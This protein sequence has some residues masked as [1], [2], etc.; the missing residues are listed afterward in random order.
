[1]FPT[2]FFPCLFFLTFLF[3]SVVFSS[4]LSL[5]FRFSLFL[6]FSFLSFSSLFFSFVFFQIFPFLCF[7]FLFC[8]FLKLNSRPPVTSTFRKPD[9]R[10]EPLERGYRIC[11][12]KWHSQ[13]FIMTTSGDYKSSFLLTGLCNRDLPI[14]RC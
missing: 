14:A 2:L 9:S 11:Q 10:H 5:S 6:F 8:I 4:F 13:K 12:A 7:S 3:S 1:M